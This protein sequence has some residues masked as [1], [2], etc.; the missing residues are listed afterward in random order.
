MLQ[1]KSVILLASP[2]RLA[3]KI[4]KFTKLQNLFFLSISPCYWLN[5][6]IVPP[7]INAIGCSDILFLVVFAFHANIKVFY[8]KHLH[9]SALN[10]KL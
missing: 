4:T 7:Q 9:N 1:K 6:Q 8:I 3:N 5:K 10:T 2:N